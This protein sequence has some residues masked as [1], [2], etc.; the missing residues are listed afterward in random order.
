MA[1]ETRTVAYR[2][3]EKVKSGFM[4]LFTSRTLPDQVR[5]YQ[6]LG[7]RLPIPRILRYS[8]GQSRDPVEPVF[9]YLCRTE[10]PVEPSTDGV[11]F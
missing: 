5:T 3:T 4:Y 10:R 6:N 1:T 7:E 9:V 8:T 2:A 11:D